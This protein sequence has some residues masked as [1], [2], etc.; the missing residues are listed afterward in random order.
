MK[1]QAGHRIDPILIGII[2]LLSL[3]MVTM[4]LP[5]M[6]ILAKS[7]SHPLDVQA[8]KVGL[9]PVRFEF[10]NYV[11]FYHRFLI[12]LAQAYY[13]SIFITVFGTAWVVL[14]T[15]LMAFPMSRPQQ[16]FRLLKP[17]MYLVLLAYIFFPPLI[18]YF[19]SVKSYG[20]MNTRTVIIFAHTVIPFQLLLVVNFYR[21][22]PEELFNACRIDGGNDFQLF[23][24]I[25][26]PSSKAVLVTI[27]LF[28]SVLLWN[29]FLHAL[30][31]IQKPALQPLQI[32]VRGILQAGD[33][34][35][36]AESMGIYAD[37]ESTKSALI[38]L[39]T[40]PIISVYPLLQKYFAKGAL[41]GG[42]KE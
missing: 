5:F 16:E 10:G 11:Y 3:V 37:K 34:H 35:V 12:P 36:A 15:A 6:H 4:I 7:L 18:P 27:G 22:I 41:V 33:A 40:I 19:L 29:I 9:W 8:G 20:L 38:M 31:F 21:G 42:I 23:W 1:S 24:H 25:A 26:L 17:V 13:N 28:T 14:N 39:T 30:L 2:G 32:F